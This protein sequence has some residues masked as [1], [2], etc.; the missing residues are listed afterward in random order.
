MN[1][2]RQT[3]SSAS[4]V[5]DASNYGLVWAV[6]CLHHRFYV[7][8]TSVHII[9]VSISFHVYFHIQVV[10]FISCFGFIG[11]KQPASFH[12]VA[13]IGSATFNHGVWS[14]TS[15]KLS[16]NDWLNSSCLSDHFLIL[17]IGGVKSRVCIMKVAQPKWIKI[18][19][20]QWRIESEMHWISKICSIVCACVCILSPIR[21]LRVLTART[22]TSHSCTRGDGNRFPSSQGAS[23]IVVQIGIGVS[24]NRFIRFINVP[25]QICSNRVP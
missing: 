11:L 17:R 15:E 16:Q 13:D 12:W 19:C 23:P 22:N 21:F 24:S 5:A 2:D 1:F 20:K 6:R 18:Q 4:P 7:L 9:Y 8:C 25:V 14:S 10:L 3:L